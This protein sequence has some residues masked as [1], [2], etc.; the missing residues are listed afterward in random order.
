MVYIITKYIKD[1]NKIYY[2][3][4]NNKFNKN[5]Y[6]N[7]MSELL[8]LLK[9]TFKELNNIYNKYIL[10]PKLKNIL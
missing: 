8:I 2:Y 3:I 4:I 9:N 1:I 7:C 6:Y 5:N 10:I